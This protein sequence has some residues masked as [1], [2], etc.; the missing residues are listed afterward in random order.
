M[1]KH[2]QRVKLKFLTP[3]I[4]VITIQAAIS[5]SDYIYIFGREMGI[6][7]G[8]PV[9]FEGGVVTECQFRHD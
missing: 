4:H 6:G 9:F 1:A 7:D 8:M 2:S 3:A 5:P